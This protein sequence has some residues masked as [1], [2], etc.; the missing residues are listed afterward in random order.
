[1]AVHRYDFVSLIILNIR[2][3]IYL[4]AYIFNLSHRHLFAVLIG[5]KQK[6]TVLDQAK[7][8]GWGQT[9]VVEGAEGAGRAVGKETFYFGSKPGIVDL[10]DY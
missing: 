10:P 5:K 9:G 4:R 3:S 7:I 6:A 8:A 1:M 2:N